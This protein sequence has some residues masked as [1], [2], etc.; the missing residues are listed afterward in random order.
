M[1]VEKKS[2]Q[3]DGK[4]LSEV[5]AL[6]ATPMFGGN[7]T[8]G[9]KIG[10]ERLISTCFKHGV[11]ISTHYV[12]DSCVARARNHIADEF[13][14]G[15]HTHLVCI[16][17]DISF[18]P[19]Y[20]LH[21]LSL[22]QGE[23]LVIGA[24]YPKKIIHWDRIKLACELGFPAKDLERLSD[25]VFNFGVR[26]VEIDMDL[27]EPVE[28]KE[29]GFGLTVIHRSVFE[30]IAKHFPEYIYTPDGYEEGLEGSR[31]VMA[32]FADGVDTFYHTGRFLTEDFWFCA[33]AR[34]VGV[35]IFV[36]PWMELGHQGPF[37]YQGSLAKLCQLHETSQV[38]KHRWL[39]IQ[40]WFAGDKVFDEQISRVSDGGIFVELGAWKGRG[41]CY[42]AGRIQESGKD[43]KLFAVDNFLGSPTEDEH[44]KD[45]ERANGKLYDTFARNVEPFGDVIV[46]VKKDTAEAAAQFADASVDFIYVDADHRRENVAKDLAAWWPKLKPDGVM[47]GDDW[48]WTGVN[49][50]VK[51]FFY[52]KKL[53]IRVL[54]SSD[55]YRPQWVVTKDAL[56]V[57]E[58]EAT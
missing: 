46:T 50:A 3:I 5:K 51:D 12:T 30:R 35:K 36:C 27:D 40:G 18:D 10:C 6:L 9:Y 2:Y 14:R 16:D 19:F 43:I 20:V 49:S 17:A 31:P 24:T 56:D 23:R 58:A 34:K 32:Y 42:A 7:C 1:R 45:Y 55:G 28:V 47:A 41:T 25:M 39:N 11:A 29:I 37:V 21:L 48:D 13:M 8:G 52:E 22:C 15:D 26:E 38:G 33:L 4:A 44:L 57:D 53:G 54:A